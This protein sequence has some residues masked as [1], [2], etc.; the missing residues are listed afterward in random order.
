MTELRHQGLATRRRVLGDAYVDRAV[1]AQTAAAAPFQALISDAAWGHGR[2][3]TPEVSAKPR[4]SRRGLLSIWL[5]FPW[6]RTTFRPG[7][8]KTRPI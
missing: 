1:A 5:R 7:F 6:G 2:A 4:R 8:M 3:A